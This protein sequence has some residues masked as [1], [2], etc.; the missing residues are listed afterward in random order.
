[1]KRHSIF[2]SALTT[3]FCASG[4]M[5]EEAAPT[6]ANPVIQF[7]EISRKVVETGG[8]KLTLI[9]VRPPVLPEPA[10]RP[11][12]EPPREP[13]Q[14]E[15]AEML[16]AEKKRYVTLGVSVTVYLR[17]GE[18]PISELRWRDAE[19]ETEYKAWSNAD[20][21]YLTQL[22]HLETDEVVYFW[23]PFVDSWNLAE[24]PDDHKNPIPTEVS[25]TPGGPTEYLLDSRATDTETEKDVL[26]GLDYL[27]AYYQLH[28][29]QLKEIHETLWAENAAREK[30]LREN[31]PVRPDTV[32]HFWPIKS[33][34]T[35]RR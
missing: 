21:R 8:H 9:R 28:F 5:A 1:M 33:S 15:L 26:A 16:A 12:M 6:L 22:N 10:P 30:D 25:F 34:K 29:P 13:T 14:E 7:E 11:E 32:I 23:F 20:F 3:M 19:R 35:L 4:L 17:E 24:L 31:P 27:H 18:P 2:I